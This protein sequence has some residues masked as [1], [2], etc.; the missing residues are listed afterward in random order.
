LSN[1]INLKRSLV[2]IA[3]CIALVLA[4]NIAANRRLFAQAM[5]IPTAPRPAQL[6]TAKTVFISNGFDLKL[7]QGSEYDQVYAAVQKLNRF[8]IVSTPQDADL[9]LEFSDGGNELVK[10]L[11]I[12]DPKTHTL[13]WS[14]REFAN[15]ATRRETLDKNEQEAVDRL[16]ADLQK[17][18]APSN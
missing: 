10:I 7:P 3:I 16:A 8:T 9:I 11:H 5:A 2:R 4:F 17:I 18:T 14:I 12:V 13:L 6:A 1:T 15:S